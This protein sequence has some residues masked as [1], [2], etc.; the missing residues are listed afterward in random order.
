MKP[1]SS[2][3]AVL[4]TFVLVLAGGA[5]F[6]VLPGFTAYEKDRFTIAH[7]GEDSAGNTVDNT[8][9]QALIDSVTAQASELLPPENN[10]YD[11]SVQ[12]EALCKANGVTITA[13]SVTPQAS[14]PDATGLPSVTVSL[15][16]QGQYAAVQNTVTGLTTLSRLV[17]IN[18]VVVN[19]ETAGKNVTL[20][21]GTIS[22]QVGASA[23]Y[24]AAVK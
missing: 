15:G 14:A 1:L 3:A 4:S 18:Q 12:I 7:F 9:R 19:N 22:A 20:P 23:Y 8:A 17:N 24:L 11:L 6:F 2:F 5:W 16:I 10:E 21:A 13:L